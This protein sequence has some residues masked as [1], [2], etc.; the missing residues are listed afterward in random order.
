MA[1]HIISALSKVL[2]QQ[3]GWK[4]KI[5]REWNNILGPLARKVTLQ[6]VDDHAVVLA[7]THPGLAQE[8]L[9][10]SDLIRDKINASIG[11][12]LITTIHFRTTAQ[13]PLQAKA[14]VVRPTPTI[15]KQVLLPHEERHLD[16]IN[17]KE[18]RSAMADFYARCKNRTAK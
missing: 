13:R 18:L 16:V 17:N 11:T 7:V 6:R 1:E 15:E 4:M 14:P 2:P 8:L 10:L 9:M 5:L 12:A 3:H